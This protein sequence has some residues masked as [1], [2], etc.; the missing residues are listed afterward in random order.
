MST[1]FFSSSGL[2]F[3]D[4]VDSDDIPDDAVEISLEIY[5]M[6]LQGE[7]DGKK[8]SFDADG[9]PILVDRPILQNDANQERLW[10]NLA[11]VL[12]DIELNKVQDGDKN[13]KGSV[14][15]WRTYRKELREW[16]ESDN[17]PSEA[18]RPVAPQ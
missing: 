7:G 8:I 16:P 9:L 18:F 10:R 15:G 5:Y 1:K 6:L 12:A 17:F 3:Y 4:S 13:A 14:A 2:S 11:L